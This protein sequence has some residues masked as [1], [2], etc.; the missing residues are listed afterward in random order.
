MLLLDHLRIHRLRQNPWL[1]DG[2]ISTAL[3]VAMLLDVATKAVQPGQHPNNAL[4]YLLTV[5]MAVPFAVH[6][7]YP[8][9]ALAVVLASVFVYASEAFAAFPGVNAFV[10]LFGIALHSERRRSVIAFVATGLGMTAAVVLQPGHGI[11]GMRERAAVFGGEFSARPR[12]GRRIAGRS[13]VAVRGVGIM[14][15]W[16]SWRMIRPWCGQASAFSLIGDKDDRSW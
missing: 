8:V 16:W 14:I 3:L 1:V 4:T 6:R 2:I 13:T 9:A 5:S 11:I 15:R 10:L 12:P 7:R